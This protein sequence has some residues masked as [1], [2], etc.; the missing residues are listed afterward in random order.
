MMMH[1]DEIE[2]E[3]KLMSCVYAVVIL[4][5]NLD[6]VVVNKLIDVY[7]LYYILHTLIT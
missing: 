1:E 5:L 6:F 2:I 3:T 4:D 7:G